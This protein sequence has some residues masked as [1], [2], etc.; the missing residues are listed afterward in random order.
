[1][2]C[3][4]VVVLAVLL[5]TAI[6]APSAATVT[7]HTGRIANGISS[8]VRYTSRHDMRAG[9]AVLDT[10]TGRLRSGGS[11]RFFPSASVVKT[12]IA[13]RL[14]IAGRMHGA[15]ARKAWV[16]I[17]RS[18]N[19]AAWALYPK[20]GRDHL[21]PWL[22]R[23]YRDR[24][25][26]TPAM[27]GIWGSTRLTAAGLVRFYGDVR[28]DH[29][30]WRWLSRAMHAYKKTSSAGE[31]NAFGIAAIAPHSAVKNG[32][33]TNRDPAHPTNAI[34][35]TTGFVAHDRYAVAILTE[36]PG[37]LYYA[38]GER[39]VTR[40]AARILPA[41]FSRTLRPHSPI[42]THVCTPR[43]GPPPKGG[44]TATALP[45]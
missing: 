9:V 12:M 18:D 37:R 10:R 21:L 35:N 26:A 22:E 15:I 30:V 42:R 1:M 24:F 41:L 29:S 36:G 28:A 32:W 38:R 34:I 23:H 2:F 31:P 4:L 45:G 33:D 27:A 7:T 13:A 16:M 11:K 3:R 40:A 8:A 5:L 44:T 14:L 39:I 43:S 25:G 17:T 6:A 19:D 20:V